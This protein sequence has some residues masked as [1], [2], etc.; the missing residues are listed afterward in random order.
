MAQQKCLGCGKKISTDADKCP[1]CGER[2]PTH[3]YRSRPI[4]TKSRFWIFFMIGFV[5]VSL[6]FLIQ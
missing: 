6:A 3:A 4:H 1:K 5:I 2:E